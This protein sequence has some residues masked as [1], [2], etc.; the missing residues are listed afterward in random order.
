[1]ISL[2]ISVVIAAKNSEKTF[3]ECLASIEKNNVAEIIV[4]DGNSVDKTVDI[5]KKYTDRVYSDEGRGFNYAQQFGAEQATQEYIAF[6]DADIVLPAGTLAKLLVELKTSD[7]ISMQAKQLA[8]SSSNYWERCSD[9]NWK[10]SHERRFGG[11][12][13]AVIR[14]S[15]VLKYKLNRTVQVGSDLALEFAAKHDGF[16]LGISSNAIAYHHHRADLK[17]VVRQRYRFGKESVNFI[18]GFGPLHIGFWPP[19]VSIYWVMLCIAKGK[20]SFVPFFVLNG[21][22][23]TA[24][25]LKGFSLLKKNCGVV[26][27]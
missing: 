12:S 26:Y 11:L 15:I 6:V 25:L 7:C 8:A 10:L 3:E 22:V 13:T 19:F 14:K 27:T 24:G 18:R 2:P 9:W 21:F 23:Q 20:A 16:K 5:A 1:L 17:A 4:V